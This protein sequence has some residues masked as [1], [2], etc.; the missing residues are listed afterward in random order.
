MNGGASD[1]VNKAAQQQVH[2]REEH[3][4][5]LSQEREARSYEVAG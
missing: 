1:K 3:G 5:N 4:P 2:E